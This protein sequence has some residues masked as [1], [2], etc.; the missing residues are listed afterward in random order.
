MS[1]YSLYCQAGWDIIHSLHPSRSFI[2]ASGTQGLGRLRS[3]FPSPRRRIVYLQ[4][5]LEIHCINS[6]SE[7]TPKL[8]FLTRI[9]EIISVATLVIMIHVES[10][11]LN[12]YWWSLKTLWPCNALVTLGFCMWKVSHYW[13]HWC[14]CMESLTEITKT[15]ETQ[16]ACV[17]THLQDT[18]K[19]GRLL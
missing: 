2:Q 3:K 9:W 8:R 11:K 12:S 17:W 19:V 6:L 13:W 14:L 10:I 16:L 5:W 18:D 4:R 7:T 15:K 1:S